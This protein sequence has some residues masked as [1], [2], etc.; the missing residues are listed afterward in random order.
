MND[1]RALYHDTIVD[2]DRNPRHEGPLPNA[3]HSATVDNPLCGDVVTMRFVVEDGVIKDAAFEGRGC[4]LSRASASIATTRAIGQTPEQ[5]LELA[6]RL[7]QFLQSAPSDAP[8]P[9]L[10]EL[11][12]FGGVRSFKS[13]RTC[14]CLP[15]RALTSALRTS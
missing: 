14:A 7:G 10:G 11:E 8:P 1:P 2:H 13:R 3:T 9:D 4:A 12:V 6:G 5:V 15:F